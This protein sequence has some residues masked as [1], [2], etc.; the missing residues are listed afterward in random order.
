MAVLDQIMQMKN[1]GMPDQEISNKLQEQ[2]VAPGAIMEAFEQIKIKEAVAGEQK[3]MQDQNEFQEFEQPQQYTAQDSF[4]QENTQ[5]DSYATAQQ[6]EE[7]YPQESYASTG[8]AVSTDTII[9]FAEQVFEEKGKSM[10]EKID[11]LKEFAT[12]AE[13]KINLFEKTSRKNRKNY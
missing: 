9:E 7:Y 1:Q 10:H 12:I 13:T 8:G 6:T 3:T 4:Q 2:G 11:S 5:Y